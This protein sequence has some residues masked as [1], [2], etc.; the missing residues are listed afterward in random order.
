MNDVVIIA[1]FALSNEGFSLLIDATNCV[2]RFPSGG[3]QLANKGGGGT[4]ALSAASKWELSIV[5]FA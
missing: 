1:P 4:N 5:A 3:F 2:V